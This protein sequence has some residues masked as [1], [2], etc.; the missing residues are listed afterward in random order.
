MASLLPFGQFPT[1]CF[2]GVFVTP[3]LIWYSTFRGMHLCV[4]RDYMHLETISFSFS[5]PA[6]GDAMCAIR[7]E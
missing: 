1:G 2:G 3:P 7:E 4:S 6:T 5:L